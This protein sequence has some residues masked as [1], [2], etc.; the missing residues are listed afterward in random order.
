M[1]PTSAVKF[2]FMLVHTVISCYSYVLF[3]QE[4]EVSR[5]IMVAIGTEKEE[6]VLRCTWDNINQVPQ[7]PLVTYILDK[8]AQ[9]GETDALVSCSYVVLYIFLVFDISP[10]LFFITCSRV[11][12]VNRPFQRPNI[13]VHYPNLLHDYDL[14][15]PCY[16][17]QQLPLSL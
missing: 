11:E 15:M 6:H 17:P 16:S 8:V 1:W 5:G 2:I 9:G 14:L 10:L 7:G 13:C 12:F 3:M 4:E